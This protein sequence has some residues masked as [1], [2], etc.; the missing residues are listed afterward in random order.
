M[1]D[2]LARADVVVS[3]HV[4]EVRPLIA[5]HKPAATLEQPIT[6]HD[7]QWHEA[8]V[9]VIAVHKGRRVPRSIR[10]RFPASPDVAWAQATKLHAGQH[11][12]F[13]LKRDAGVY[14]VIE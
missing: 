11:G 7:A 4:S 6:E 9:E 8:I 10:V 3:G 1:D 5:P 13:L 2:R 12:T 14:T